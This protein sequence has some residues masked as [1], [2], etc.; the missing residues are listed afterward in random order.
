MKLLNIP[1]YDLSTESDVEQKFIFPLLTHPSFLAIPAKNILT[2]KSMG[3]FRFVEKASLPKGYVPDYMIFIAGL[4]V[5]VI[6]AKAPGVSVQQAISEARTYADHLNKQFATRVNPVGI[7]VGCNGSE[8]AFGPV[9][10]NDSEIISVGDLFIG[11]SK[12][13]KLREAFGIQRLTSSVEK[14][15]RITTAAYFRPAQFL[16]P[17]LFVERIEPNALAP[18]LAPLYEMFFRSEDPE[19]NK[20]ILDRAYVDTA[21]LREYDQVLHAMLRQI[22]RSLPSDYRT[23][24]T[25]RNQEYTLNL[26]LGRYGEDISSKGRMHLIIGSRGSG[27]SLFISRF[28]THLLAD[29]LRNNAVWCVIDFNRAPSSI[30][31]IE[32]YICSQFVEH[33]DNLKFDIHSLEGLRRIFSVDINRLNKGPIAAISDQAEREKFLSLELLKLTADTKGF[34]QKLGRY[35]T[36]DAHR[37]LIIA[38]DNV[39]RRESA[40]QLHIFQAAQWFRSETRA[41]ALLTLRDVTFERFKNE[42][43]LDAFAQ[44]SNFYI[45]PPRFSLVLQ[46]RLRLAIDHGLQDLSAVE[47]VTTSGIKFKYTPAQLGIFLQ[48]IYDALFGSE[49]QVGQIVDALSERDVRAALGMF[50]RILSSGH[51]NADRLISVGTGG[52][53]GIKSDT[54]I[55]ILMRADYR[56]YSEQAAFIKNIFS[57]PKTGYTGNIFINAEIL[58]FFARPKTGEVRPGGYFSLEELLSDLASM[59][60]S[61]DEIRDRVNALAQQKLLA[62]DGEETE[63]PTDKDLIKITPSGIIHLRTLPQLIEYISSCALHMPFSD[64]AVAGRVALTWEKL[65]RYRD[66]S[67]SFKHDV[68]GMVADYLVRH[69]SRMDN[70]NPLFKER[71]RE[72][73]TLVRSISYAVNVSMRAAERQR[74]R[75]QQGAL[76]KRSGRSG[77]T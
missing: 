67:F 8:I 42:P 10:T 30:S 16:D 41:F 35:I 38:F 45:R 55:K 63:V 2:K 3:S 7:V 31:N 39:D 71:S 19:K 40:Q 62:Y 23:I 26:E 12:V 48:S 51:F 36:G 46:K 69:K 9:D 50:S 68:A 32:D 27:K 17:Q 25:D 52:E 59:G 58:G 34:A 44:M 6:E 13:E 28:F 49:Q 29:F 77:S 70:E 65:R 14:L 20:L 21:E 1:S 11:S 76:A 74:Q 5:C 54:L 15:R 22:E 18:Y 56:V 57:V 37:P 4:P 24:E 53:D 43:P 72:S 61:E 66:L 33:A 64:E 60:F 75:L 73:E 47:Q